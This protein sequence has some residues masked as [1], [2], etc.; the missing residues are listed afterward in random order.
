MMASN[1]GALYDFT[2]SQGESLP[3]NTRLRLTVEGYLDDGD[4]IADESFSVPVYIDNEAPKLYTD[5]IAYLYNPYADTRRLEFYVSDNYG[6]A[7]VVPLTASGAAFDAVTVENVP[8]GKVLVSLDVTG[9]DSSFL[10]AVCDY[11]CNETYYE[12]SF[13]GEYDI[14]FD[15]FYGYRHVQH[16]S[17]WELSVCHRRAERLVFL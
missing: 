2:D 9:Y 3:N 16:G 8:G 7:A 14:N 17:Q 4:E 12:I 1:Y 10:L 15:A 13:S 11:G 5:E 6:V